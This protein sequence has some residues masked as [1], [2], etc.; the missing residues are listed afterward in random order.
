MK[1]NKIFKI[2]MIGL[3][4]ISV[5]L[6]IWGSL[7]GFESNGARMVDILFYWTY[8]MVGIALVAW[9]IFGTIKAAQNNPKS[10]IK[11]LIA[12]V[13]IAIICVVAYLLA[14]GKP[15]IGYTGLPVSEDT[16]KLTDTVLYLTYFAGACAI[17][18]I[19]IGEIR[20]SVANK[21]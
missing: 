11:G 18:A 8:V 7:A 20:M 21:K 14:P 13:G 3:V 12:I 1:L 15:A 6:V 2:G 10:L 17:I 16:L 19:V 4:V 9:I 5:A